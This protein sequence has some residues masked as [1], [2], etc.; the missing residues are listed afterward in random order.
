MNS[1]TVRAILAIIAQA[2]L[3]L[4]ASG[5]DY[6]VTILNPDGWYSFGEG[7]SGATQVGYGATISDVNA[8]HALL[9]NN[10]AES[11]VDLHPAGFSSSM[12]YATS[13]SSQVGIAVFEGLNGEIFTHAQLWNG[14]AASAIDLNSAGL[15]NSYTLA[16]S[17]AIQVGRGNGSATGF[18][19]HALMWTGSPTS[20]VDLNPSGSTRSAASAILGATVV[21][22][23]T[24]NGGQQH[25]MLWH[26]TSS[27]VDLHPIGF[28][29][30]IAY[31]VSDTLEVGSAEN[32]S[33]KNHA[34]LWHGTAESA[35]DL[36]PPGYI[37]SQAK[38]VSGSIEVGYGANTLSPSGVPVAHALAWNGTATSF[39]DLHSFLPADFSSSFASGISENGTIVGYAYGPTAVVAVM[40]TPVPEPSAILLTLLSAPVL[41]AN[42]RRR[43]TSHN[44]S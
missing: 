31:G 15:Q 25:A 43:S 20:V 23:G 28:L 24:P 8:Q 7:I 29:S 12:A 27:T 33:L 16:V 32:F 44:C 1:S 18:A 17:G 30:S 10:T 26:G 9:W 5:A 13:G 39:V 40:W 41:F 36:N 14:S 3:V 21:G 4:S 22:Y 42:R 38:A 19:D 35:I 6:K 34:L 37:D 11:F 2:L